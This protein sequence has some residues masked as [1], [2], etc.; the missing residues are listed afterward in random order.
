MTLKEKLVNQVFHSRAD[1]TENTWNILGRRVKKNY[2]FGIIITLLIVSNFYFAYTWQTLKTRNMNALGST[3]TTAQGFFSETINVFNN[4][5]VTGRLDSQALYVIQNDM[6]QATRYIQ[7]TSTLD[8]TRSEQWNIISQATYE[9][10]QVALQILSGMATRNCTSIELST[11]A[12]LYLGSVNRELTRVMAAFPSEIV[13]GPTPSIGFD[14][15]MI[16]IA[17]EAATGFD[18]VLSDFVD[19]V[20]FASCT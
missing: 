2:V 14:E 7:L 3:L 4:T 6:I 12:I 5:M 8:S 10:S 17:A 15:A 13:I 20:N 11:D 18:G 16:Q 9:M 19:S 1:I